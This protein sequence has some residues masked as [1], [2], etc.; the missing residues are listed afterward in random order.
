MCHPIMQVLHK[1]PI[2]LPVLRT[3]KGV[4]NHVATISKSDVFDEITKD[5]AATLVKK[6][7]ALVARATGDV[8]QQARRI[9]VTPAPAAAS[10]PPPTKKRSDSV[11]TT[12]ADD[13]EARKK[14]RG[15]PPSGT[16]GSTIAS[17]SSSTTKSSATEKSAAA[18]TGARGTAPLGRLPTTVKPAAKALPSFAKRKPAPASAP[19]PTPA[20]KAAPAPTAA[21]AFD[22]F[23]LSLQDMA[24][25]KESAAGVGM[26]VGDT[27]SMLN[28]AVD[29]AS[30]T[31]APQ[32]NIPRA[33]QSKKKSVR[34]AED[35]KLRLIKYVEKL[36]YGDEFGNEITTSD[37]FNTQGETVG[38]HEGEA[39]KGLME[40][41]DWEEP[42][43]VD[44]KF[45]QE[46]L[47]LLV[48]YPHPELIESG[49]CERDLQAER[50]KT[51]L[52]TTYFTDE[53][54]PFSPAE[55]TAETSTPSAPAVTEP[56]I[57]RLSHDLANDQAV[58]LSIFH[59]QTARNASQM[60]STGY[61]GNQYQPPQPSLYGQSATQ[62]I[63]PAVAGADLNTLL[64]QL[65][66]SGLAALNPAPT[67]APY[68][69][70]QQPQQ[71]PHMQP[72]Q[73]PY[74]HRY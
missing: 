9:S 46:D 38:E 15:S 7:K 6:W 30:N 36:V 55:P 20:A 25:S 39:M 49:K 27:L 65:S 54:I 28:K 42:Q 14:R 24:A 35:D 16:A 41:I 48:E 66:G 68:M 53:E 33:G 12:A 4:G 72:Y 51:I 40:Q 73:Q 10:A 21:P 37:Y 60:A 26:S 18:S 71:Y 45:S 13:E 43:L 34:W 22:P 50:E 5:S 2:T 8:P 59:A 44:R 57:M 17:T 67:P 3:L 23:A 19:K 58:Q 70:H 29:A 32:S 52:A 11:V 64:A 63:P 69:Q 47:D 61:S 62:E 31:A 1:L 74:Q 56:V